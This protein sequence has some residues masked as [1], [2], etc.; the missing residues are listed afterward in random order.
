M[1][2]IIEQL[3]PELLAEFAAAEQEAANAMERDARLQPEVAPS[4]DTKLRETICEKCGTGLVWIGPHRAQ[5]LKCDPVDVGGP[6][7]ARER[8][9]AMCVQAAS[10]TVCVRCGG[11]IGEIDYDLRSMVEEGPADHCCWKCYQKARAGVA[12]AI[13]PTPVVLPLADLRERLQLCRES[14]VEEYR[15][16]PIVIRFSSD[17]L[18]AQRELLTPMPQQPAERW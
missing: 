14:G 2:D 10:P 3:P 17:L 12:D 13:A 7:S 9:E 15:D 4:E 11:P 16:G 18:R 5:C 8:V 6:K 1:T